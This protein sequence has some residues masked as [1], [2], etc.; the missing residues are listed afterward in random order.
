MAHRTTIG[1]LGDETC[2]P[3][4]LFFETALGAAQRGGPNLDRAISERREVQPIRLIKVLVDDRI[5]FCGTASVSVVQVGCERCFDDCALTATARI[6]LG[7]ASAVVV[8]GLLFPER[9]VADAG[10]FR[11]IAQLVTQTMTL[12]RHEFGMCVDGS[13]HPE[14]GNVTSPDHAQQQLLIVVATLE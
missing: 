13:A 12:H 14:V 11:V 2:L 1:G 8:V 10:L 6:R 5:E 9:S 4:A 3:R 7:S